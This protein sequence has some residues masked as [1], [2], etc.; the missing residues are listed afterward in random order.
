VQRIT[1]EQ[2]RKYAFDWEDEPL[3][4]VRPGESFEVETYDA[5]T[6]YFKTPAD[7]AIP[8]RRPGFDRSPPLANPIGG[9]VYLEGAERGDTL[10]VQ[11]EDIL[12]DDYSWIA[13][14]PRRGPLGE[15]TRWPELS[16]EYTTK[17]FRHTPGP[18]GTTRDGT[19]HFNDRISWPVTPFLGTLG[20]APEREVT[21][22]LDG[23]GE[24]GGN[25]DIRDATVGNRLLLPVFHPGAL[26]YLGDVHASQGDTEFTGTA[27]ET[28]ATV[29]V[30]LDLIKGK[31]IPWLRIEKP[32]SLVA[33]YA[34]R[35]LEVA[36]ETATVYLMDWLIHEYGFTPTD[37]YCLVSTCPD[38][39][40]NVYQMCKIGKL[41]FVAGA[42]IPRK[43]LG[44]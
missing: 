8:A 44:T 31:R 15:S 7:K 43:Y 34:S 37:A 18:S 33:V 24:W 40:I 39:R 29:R 35:P 32:G 11:V 21:T 26:F 16:G 27:A 5:S 19:I 3:L 4:R 22:S 41:S 36:V 38:F 10:V 14:G 2:A 9:P 1:R 13:V 30:K 42:E 6:G 17:V 28:K 25:L 23:Q 20:V 12:V